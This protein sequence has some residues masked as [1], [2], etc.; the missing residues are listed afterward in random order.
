[1]GIKIVVLL[2]YCVNCEDYYRQVLSH[3]SS[4]IAILSLVVLL[5]LRDS[6]LNLD[7]EDEEGPWEGSAPSALGLTHR[8]YFPRLKSKKRKLLWTCL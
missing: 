5:T 8:S 6:S 3:G 2:R 4:S 7:Y 1:M